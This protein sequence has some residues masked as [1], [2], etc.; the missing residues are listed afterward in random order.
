MNVA[1]KLLIIVQ[2]FNLLRKKAVTLRLCLR[3]N[4]EQFLMTIFDAISISEHN[5]IKTQLYS[6]HVA[7]NRLMPYLLY[8][9]KM[10]DLLFQ[11]LRIVSF[12]IGIKIK[13]SFK[14]AFSKEYK[15]ADFLISL[16]CFVTF[17][18]EP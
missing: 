17:C 18:F 1:F 7:S 11:T 14:C 10:K 5:T 4:I 3:Q 12:M 15:N 16:F 8:Q 6:N 2:T 13:V 9:T